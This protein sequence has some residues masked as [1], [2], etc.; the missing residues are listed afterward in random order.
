[1]MI[2]NKKG[3][4]GFMEAMAAFM[5]VTVAMTSFLGMLTYSQLG[6]SDLKDSVGDDLLEGLMLEGDEITGWDDRRL[7]TFAERNGYNCARITIIVAGDLCDASLERA[8][9]EI[10]GDNVGSISGNF[11]ISSDDGR[12]FAASYEVVYWWD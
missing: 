5:V 7:D 6:S 8:V 12:T 2:K 10:E 1:M 3:E 9:G 4:G 11:T